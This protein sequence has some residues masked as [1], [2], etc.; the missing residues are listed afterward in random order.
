MMTDA[1]TWSFFKIALLVTGEGEEKSL[2]QLFRS[3]AAEGYCAFKVRA[4]IP[5]LGPITSQKR[6]L[7]M[8]GKGKTIPTE[9]EKIGEIARGAFAAGYDYVILVDDLEYDRATQVE[10][11][12]ARYRAALDTLLRPRNL[13]ARASVHFLVNMLEAYF[14]ADAAAVNGVLGTT[15]ADHAGDVETIRHP[16]NDLKRLHRGYNEIEH[17]GKILSQLD[18]TRV[19]ANPRTCRS[20]RTLFGWCSRAIGRP[21]DEKYQL[22]EGDYLDLTRPQIDALPAS[23]ATAG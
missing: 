19:L 15:L 14:L 12:F 8:V 4:R 11:V 6:K 2:H 22:A 20:L 21:F 17:A 23:P 13:E 10:A 5:Q 18:V 3:L 1:S 7:K 9:D 16:K